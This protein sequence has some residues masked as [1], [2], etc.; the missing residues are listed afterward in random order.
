MSAAQLERLSDVGAPSCTLGV[1]NWRGI[2]DIVVGMERVGYWASLKKYGNG[3][4][5]STGAVEAFDTSRAAS[6]DCRPPNT[7]PTGGTRW[8]FGGRTGPR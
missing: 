8:R 6:L 4:A 7:A 1:D 5:A 2:G 3:G